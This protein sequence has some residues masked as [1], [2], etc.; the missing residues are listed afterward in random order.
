[1]IKTT[2]EECYQTDKLGRIASNFSPTANRRD[3]GTSNR[4]DPR[5]TSS[6]S[7]GKSCPCCT[8]CQYSS[9]PKS[10]IFKDHP[11]RTYLDTVSES[12]IIARCRFG[13]VMATMERDGQRHDPASNALLTAAH[14]QSYRTHRDLA[15]FNTTCMRDGPWLPRERNE[16]REGCYR[17]FNRLFSPRKP[18][19]CSGLL[20]T[21]LTITASFSRPWKPSTLPNSISGYFSLSSWLKTA[22]WAL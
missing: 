17:P 6:I 5:G 15:A 22:S 3:W 7:S 18:T 12:P 9:P 2:N 19:S 14:E 8:T 10:L 13:L 20:L 1:M 4:H 16:Q 21:K 11:Q